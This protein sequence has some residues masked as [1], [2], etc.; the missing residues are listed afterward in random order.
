MIDFSQPDKEL[1]PSFESLD[2]NEDGEIS[3]AEFLEGM[4]RAPA[5][6]GRVQAVGAC[7]GAQPHP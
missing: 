7:G 3:R 4:V 5:Q 1:M 6:L 2:A